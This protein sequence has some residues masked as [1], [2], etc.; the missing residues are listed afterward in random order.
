MRT[1][2]VVIVSIFL[3]LILGINIVYAQ[4]D[5][6]KVEAKV[7]KNN[8]IQEITQENGIIKKEQNT[9]IRILEGEYEHEEYEMNYIIS[10]D[11]E[12]KT[13]N[14]EL[15]EDDIILVSIE[16]KDGEITNVTYENIINRNYSLY[17][18][19]I[20]L[21][22]LALIIARKNAIKPLIGF[23]FTILLIAV[24]IFLVV[25]QK[26]NM[27]LI[28]SLTSLFITMFIAIKVNGINK[29]TGVMIACSIVGTAIAGI[30]A[31]ILFD[32]ANLTNINIK[33]A[34]SFINIKELFITATILFGGVLSNIIVLSSLN[35]YNFLNKPYKT[36][37]DNIIHGQRSL[38][39]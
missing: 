15:K 14:V 4:E 35:M 27:I 17:I 25:N 28:S 38:K 11:V 36:K 12:S 9:K 24:L 21:I 7:I 1:K 23:V 2:I 22:I 32:L 37:S 20:G 30:L 6:N 29:K 16:E 5:Y 26:W 34:E 3:I 31:Y 33:V 13:S 39:L 18:I 10:E 19:L 8:G